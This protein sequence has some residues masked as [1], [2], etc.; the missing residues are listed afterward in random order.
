MLLLSEGQMAAY[1]DWRVRCFLC[2]DFS[3]FRLKRMEKELGVGQV[4][5]AQEPE[6]G[7]CG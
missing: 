2:D 7:R 4:G 1:P 5:S 3:F 6:W